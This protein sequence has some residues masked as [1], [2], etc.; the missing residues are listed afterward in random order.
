MRG[1]RAADVVLGCDLGNRFID[2]DAGDKH[3]RKAS[4]FSLFSDFPISPIS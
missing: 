1:M 4:P 3:K 2:K